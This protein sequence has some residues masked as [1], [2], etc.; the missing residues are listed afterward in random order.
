MLS[1]G[2]GKGIK[3]D[4]GW[5]YVRLSKIFIYRSGCIISIGPFY[6]PCVLLIIVQHIP[7]VFILNTEYIYIALLIFDTPCTLIEVMKNMQLNHLDIVVY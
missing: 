4:G 3:F 6:V 7:Q 1:E 2:G 5:K